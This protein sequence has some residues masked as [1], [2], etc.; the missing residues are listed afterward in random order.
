VIGQIKMSTD[1]L[2]AR[3]MSEKPISYWKSVQARI[4]LLFTAALAMLCIN[5]LWRSSDKGELIGGTIVTVMI[6]G[7]VALLLFIPFTQDDD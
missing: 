1:K 2:M 4:L 3:H 5:A 6:V 7:M